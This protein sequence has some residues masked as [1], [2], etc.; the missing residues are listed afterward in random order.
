[1]AVNHSQRCRDRVEAILRETDAGRERLHRYEMRFAH[2]AEEK[3]QR[4][5]AQPEQALKRI[6]AG[7]H[8][9]GGVVH[10]ADDHGA[11]AGPRVA[12]DPP[13]AAA[14][15]EPSANM[16]VDRPRDELG[17]TGKRCSDVVEEP[18]AKRGRANEELAQDNPVEYG[19][20]PEHMDMGSVIPAFGLDILQ[21]D[22]GPVPDLDLHAMTPA[23]LKNNR[24]TF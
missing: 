9:A 17:P 5:E 12:V 1:M 4:D 3:M 22:D 20:H 7:K 2:Y 8:A 18:L 14:S 6:R 15:S 11:V 23:A 19:P 13:A 21:C 16:Q 24:K 10:V